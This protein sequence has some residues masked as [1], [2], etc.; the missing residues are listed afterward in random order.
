[1][2]VVLHFISYLK[3]IMLNRYF[4]SYIEGLLR[5]HLPSINWNSSELDR[6]T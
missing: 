2:V 3:S 1:M 6:C 4:F 5:S